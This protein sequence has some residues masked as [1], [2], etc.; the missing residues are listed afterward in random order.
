M[1]EIQYDVQSS[2]IP[3]EKET[4]DKYEI[5]NF[6]WEHLINQS[7]EKL[8]KIDIGKLVTNTDPTIF[9]LQE[10]ILSQIS[11]IRITS[12]SHKI[13]FLTVNDKVEGIFTF[14]CSPKSKKSRTEGIIFNQTLGDYK[15][16]AFIRF[17]ENDSL[18]CLYKKINDNFLIFNTQFFNYDK[19]VTYELDEA[20]N[21][22]KFRDLDDNITENDKIIC[23]SLSNKF[24]KTSR[25]CKTVKE[26]YFE[27]E[28]Q[29]ED[30][31]DPS[32]I[33]KLAKTQMLLLGL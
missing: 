22:S 10:N 26:I 12:N 17:S 7:N 24:E 3:K 27:L 6:S 11:N 30:T 5:K 15:I 25:K 14:K 33:I 28:C 18:F 29:N 21:D 31:T 1:V 4:L 20:P 2:I 23:M 8:K 16:K 9:L 19:G 13:P 32:Y